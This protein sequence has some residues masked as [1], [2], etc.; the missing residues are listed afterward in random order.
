[1][2]F[3][4]NKNIFITFLLMINTKAAFNQEEFQRDVNMTYLAKIHFAGGVQSESGP[5]MSILPC[6]AS[7]YICDNWF[8]HPKQQKIQRSMM[9]ITI[10]S[11]RVNLVLL[12]WDL[13]LCF[14]TRKGTEKFDLMLL[15]STWWS[16]CLTWLSLSHFRIC[17]YLI[18]NSS[19]IDKETAENLVQP[20][21]W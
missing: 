19:C 7:C 15:S 18:E 8:N 21:K 14:A 2:F 3:L 16:H 12:T 9:M 6:D 13:L 17:Q 11:K 5:N 20:M 4:S 10:S 1:M